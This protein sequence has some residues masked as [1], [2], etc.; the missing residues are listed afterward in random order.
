MPSPPSEP[1][2]TSNMK[3]RLL[4]A[5]LTAAATLPAHAGFVWLGTSTGLTDAPNTSLGGDGDSLYQETNWDDDAV[6]GLQAPANNAINNSTQTPAGISNA[7][8]VNN[9]FVAGGA[10]GAG[11]STA[12]FR[13]NGNTVTVS[14]A[15]SGIKMANTLIGSTSTAAAWFENDGTTGGARSSLV[16]DGGFVSTGALKDI[17]A[18]VSGTTGGIWFLSHNANGLDGNNVTIDL[19][20]DLNENSAT[21]HWVSI[22]A[23]QL[24]TAG[25]LG[26]LTVNGAPGVWGSDPLVYEEGD[27]LLATAGTY[28]R[29]GTPQ[30]TQN[31]W[32]A[33]SRSGFSMSAVPETSSALLL[34]ASAGLL[35]RRRR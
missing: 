15:G 25:V 27:N 26:S 23:E 5:A 22:T 20:G 14:G 7:V 13:T 35:A 1:S 16:I 18:T 17:A 21:L 19:T 32:Y 29:A 28:H 2:P 33:T 4:L 12:H 6:A 11:S 9:G 8:F 31:N 30:L 34:F 24:F 3:S 10:N